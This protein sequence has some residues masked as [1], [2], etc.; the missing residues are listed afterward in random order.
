MSL[1]SD[2]AVE[3]AVH[4]AFAH[5]IVMG[6]PYTPDTR[7]KP[8]TNTAIHAPFTLQA[9]RYPESAF[10]RAVEL[11][12]IFNELVDRISQ[13]KEWLLDVLAHV[14]TIHL[15]RPDSYASFSNPLY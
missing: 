7:A 4:Y 3:R 14:R 11:S 13:D 5:G 10:N 2:S 1:P 9:Y 8:V 6:A 15:S 12:T